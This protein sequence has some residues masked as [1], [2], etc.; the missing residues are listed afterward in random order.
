M[1]FNPPSVNIVAHLQRTHRRQDKHLAGN[2]DLILKSLLVGYLTIEHE[3]IRKPKVSKPGAL[4]P[5]RFYVIT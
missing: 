2:H 3:L 1:K 5:A 4:G